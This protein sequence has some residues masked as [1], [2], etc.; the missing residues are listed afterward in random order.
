MRTGAENKGDK[1][2]DSERLY[3]IPYRRSPP[4]PLR[5]LPRFG[6]PGPT[7]FSFYPYIP[8]PSIPESEPLL[9][10]DKLVTFSQSFSSIPP[11]IAPLVKAEPQRPVKEEEPKISGDMDQEQ[12]RVW[13]WEGD[14]PECLRKV[15]QE[16]WKPGSPRSHTFETL[17]PSSPSFRTCCMQTWIIWPS[18]DLASCC[19][20]SLLIPPPSMQL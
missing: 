17:L 15:G 4:H 11:H 5:P 9:G 6:E 10:A 3:Y 20:W 7:L 2:G 8:H 12:V 18:E 19:Q 13:G 14:W 16:R 1:T